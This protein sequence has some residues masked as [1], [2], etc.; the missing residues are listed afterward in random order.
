MNSNQR[1]LGLERPSTICSSFHNARLKKARLG[2]EQDSWLF[3]AELWG[4]VW[5]W[6]GGGEPSG[7]FAHRPS[8]CSITSGITREASSRKW[9]E[10]KDTR[11]LRKKTSDLEIIMLS[12]VR[13]QHHMLSLNMWN[14][15]KGHNELLCGTDTDSQTLKNVSRSS[16]H[17]TAETNPTR[18]HEVVG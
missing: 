17:G 6:V 5:G 3:P 9:P 15:K 14:L 16:H 1:M 11:G 13:H 7:P 10:I 12:E 18:N 4:P 2:K 8:D